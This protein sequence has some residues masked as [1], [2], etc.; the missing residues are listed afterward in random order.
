MLCC[1]IFWCFLVVNFNSCSKWRNLWASSARNMRFI[2][3]LKKKKELMGF[4]KLI[5]CWPKC[6]LLLTLHLCWKI[7]LLLSSPS[8]Q[9][10]TQCGTLKNKFFLCKL[11]SFCVFG[12]WNLRQQNRSWTL[13]QKKNK[14]FH[15]KKNIYNEIQKT[16]NKKTKSRTIFRNK[17]LHCNEL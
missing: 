13:V 15:K 10:C 8:I 17:Y 4:K 3:W 5:L 7:S 16:F 2:S 9:Q 1:F 11:K 6:L 12:F 14:R